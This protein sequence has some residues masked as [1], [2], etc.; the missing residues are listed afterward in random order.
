[1]I[2]HNVTFRLEGEDTHSLALRFKEAI[3][4]LPSL[5]EELDSIEVHID[6]SNIAGNWT[7][8][9]RARCADYAALAAYAGHPEHLACVAIIKSAVAA[10]A[11]VDYT[12]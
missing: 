8:Y 11:C 3:E 5:I 1:M 12:E 2:V 6:D 9:L 7:L 10:R 4:K